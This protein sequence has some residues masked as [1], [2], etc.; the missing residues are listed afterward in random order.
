MTL[1]REHRIIVVGA[2]IIGLTTAVVL[3]E[4]GNDV[5]LLGRELPTDS[6]SQH[7]ASVWAGANWCSYAGPADIREQKWETKAWEHFLKIR[8]SRPDL[9]ALIPFLQFLPT[10]VKEQNLW[11]SSLC[12]NFRVLGRI[13]D[14]FGEETF[15]ISY[16]SITIDV[17]NY[18]QYLLERAT[19]PSSNS[20]FGAPVEIHRTPS[21]PSLASVLSFLPASYGST[22]PSKTVPIIV[23]ATGLG[24]HDLDDVKDAGVQPARGQTVLVR[25]PR[26]KRCVVHAGKES[27]LS[28]KLPGD[29]D[30]K[31]EPDSLGA[32]IAELD[33]RAT[34]EGTADDQKQLA[35]DPDADQP[36]YMIPR[37]LGG[38]VIL[39]GTYQENRWVYEAEEKTTLRILSHCHKICPEIVSPYGQHAYRLRRSQ[40]A[41]RSQ[42]TSHEICCPATGEPS[43]VWTPAHPDRLLSASEALDELDDDHEAVEILRVNV[44]MRPA[45]KDGVRLERTSLSILKETS[46]HSIKFAPGQK[47]EVPIVH[48]YGLGPAGYQQS[49]G[50]A[51]AAADLVIEAATQ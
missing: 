36:T 50:V 13:P 5:L 31:K 2:G 18:L 26:V 10:E 30:D 11:F 25:A 3:R 17:P 35:D 47:R 9:I 32:R 7:F 44:G 45:R 40:F 37:A 29:G 28:P 19:S 4:Q 33:I 46:S 38:D 8:E 22:L 49:W 48:A 1:L 41:S 6:T 16:D 42:T 20:S 34:H 23:N 39:G 21:L 24:A 27:K 14:G 51:H 15:A 43:F 12:P